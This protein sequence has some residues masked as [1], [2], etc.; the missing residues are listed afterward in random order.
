MTNYLD[1]RVVIVTGAASGFGRLVC[2]GAAALGARV[3]A[4]DVDG[5]GLAGLANELGAGAIAHEADVTDA[6][7]MR[8]AATAAVKAF[9]TIDVI[10]NNAGVM[11]LAFFADHER[12]LDAWS[13]A[14]DINVKGILNGVAAVYDH[15]IAQGRGHVINISSTYSNIATEGSGVYSATKQAVNAISDSLRVEAQG[16]LKV[17][18]VRPTGVMQTNLGRSMVNPAAIVGAWGHKA[19]T[20]AESM[21][22]VMADPPDPALTDPDRTTYAW[23]GAQYI[24]DA[25]VWVMNQPWGVCVSDITVRATG[26]SFVM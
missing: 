23:L 18:V 21:G 17:T 26:E 2:Q 13:R 1:E 25:I 4:V 10:V 3:V 9:G 7:A 20:A 24:A 19:A 12:A 8:A 15:M 11:P 5:A 22:K 16:K 6:V 14:I